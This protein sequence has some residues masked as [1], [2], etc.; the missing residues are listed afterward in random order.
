MCPG[1]S[2]RARP[3]VATSGRA[4]PQAAGTTRPAALGVAVLLV[5][6]VIGG[7]WLRTGAVGDQVRHDR[8]AL[9]RELAAERTSLNALAKEVADLESRADA[10]PDVATVAKRVE[11][12]VFTIATSDGL[13]SGFVAHADASSSVIVTDYHVVKDDWEKG[14][15]GVKIRQE[16]KPDVSGTIDQVSPGDDLAAVVVPVVLPVLPKGP[17]PSVGDPVLAVGSPLG[18][19]NS[20]SSGIVSAFHDGI[21]QFSA[22]I[23]PGNSGGPVVDRTG[24]V[25]GVARSKL[26]GDGAEGLSFAIPIALVCSTIATC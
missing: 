21:I 8:L 24:R 20:V 19:G 14:R 17:P 7:L 22:P 26:V 11:A 15:R 5:A 25:V 6:A 3:P 18:L 9:R 2:D 12:S 16:G 13:G 23:S 1:T 4:R 10:Q